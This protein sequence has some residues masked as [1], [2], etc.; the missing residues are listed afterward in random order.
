MAAEI[1]TVS[2]VSQEEPVKLTR[3]EMRKIWNRNY[4]QT[5]H[6]KAA[7]LRASVK[8]NENHPDHNCNMY[9]KYRE[10]M[11]K[12]QREFYQKNR[13]A[14][15]AKMKEKRLIKINGTRNDAAVV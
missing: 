12:C 14:I 4:A 13:E 7:K 11:K 15:L 10:T 6:G 8:Y 5:E 9:E 1:T 3:Q 2:E